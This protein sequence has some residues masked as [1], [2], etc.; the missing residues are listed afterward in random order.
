MSLEPSAVLHEEP[1][2]VPPNPEMVERAIR[3]R[4]TQEY[5]L[6][7]LA[8]A[9]ACTARGSLGALLRR[10]GLFH[11]QLAEFRKWKAQQELG[12]CPAQLA[13]D[14][15]AQAQL[16][17]QSLLEQENRAL[18]RQLAKAEQIITIQKKAAILLGETLQEMQIGE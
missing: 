2:R 1:L 8:Q 13:H 7:V 18:R 3:R 16:H 9:D 5:K 6:S 10:E 17:R 14:P 15:A 4:F 11:S 12:V